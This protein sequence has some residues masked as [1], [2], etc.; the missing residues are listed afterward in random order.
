MMS[1][2]IY[3]PGQQV[4]LI[5]NPS[6][7]HNV[8]DEDIDRDGTDAFYMI[9]LRISLLVE[10]QF[11]IQISVCIYSPYAFRSEADVLLLRH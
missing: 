8:A 1:I 11:E 5:F 3:R 4:L 2:S 7:L 6:R 9:G 10:R